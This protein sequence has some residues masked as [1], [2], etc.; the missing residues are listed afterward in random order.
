MLQGETMVLHSRCIYFEANSRDRG[1][2]HTYLQDEACD[3]AGD[4]QAK[5]LEN[6][7]GAGEGRPHR[8][9]LKSSP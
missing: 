8:S 3:N 9:R 7:S 1:E 6:T 2:E 4:R 5:N